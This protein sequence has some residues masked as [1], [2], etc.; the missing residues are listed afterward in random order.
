VRGAGLQTAVVVGRRWQPVCSS[1]CCTGVGL[2]E[3]YANSLLMLF[4]HA[5]CRWGT[6]PDSWFGLDARY[7]VKHDGIVWDL[8]EWKECQVGPAPQAR[9]T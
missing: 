5:A 6:S 2:V 8:T 9:C 7:Y 3:G 1:V 4:P